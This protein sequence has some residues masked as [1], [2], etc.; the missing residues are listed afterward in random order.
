MVIVIEDEYRVTQ[1]DP[2]VTL[3]DVSA[4]VEGVAVEFK[5]PRKTAIVVR[6]SDVFTFY[7]KDNGTTP[8]EIP[9]P[10]SVKVR[11]TDPNGILQVDKA[12]T[13]YKVVKE[14]VNR[15]SIFK[16]NK[17][18]TLREDQYLQIVVKPT[19]L[20]AGATKLD[21]TTIQFQ[22]SCRRIAELIQL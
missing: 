6:P 10:V 2:N 5:C 21:K 15:E 1:I 14:W 19:G 12:T 18:F 17:G 3:S 4:D 13:I 11:V 20:S 8:T 16:F 7:A 9:D 22:I